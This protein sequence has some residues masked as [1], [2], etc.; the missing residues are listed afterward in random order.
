M[1]AIPDKI[2][3]LETP[4]SESDS[5][6]EEFEFML[7]WYG[8][9]GSFYS[10]LFTDWE[11]SQDV[12]ARVLN[13]SDPDKLSSIILAEERAVRLVAEDLTLNDLKIISSIFIAKNIIRIFKDET[14]E[15]IG[16]AGN[17]QTFKQTD[18]R[19]N[20]TFDVLQYEKALPK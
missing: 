4:V 6:Y 3:K 18:G 1:S 7:G 14:T 20:L 9:D 8:R 12:D 17:S 19:Y 2:F 15:R 13:I 11:E 5:N 16:I 10:Y